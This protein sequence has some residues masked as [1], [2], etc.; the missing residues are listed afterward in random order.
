LGRFFTVRAYA[1]P[2]K[3][4]SETVPAFYVCLKTKLNRH[5]HIFSEL[6]M[7]RRIRSFLSRQKAMQFAN[8]IK[9][10]VIISLSVPTNILK[11]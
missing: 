7:N 4:P 1:R 2:A 10:A 6:F 3:S 9:T 8:I 5:E 11:A